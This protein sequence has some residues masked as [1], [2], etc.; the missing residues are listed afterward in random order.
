LLKIFQSDSAT[1]ALSTRQP[2][3]HRT[4]KVLLGQKMV[5]LEVWHPL[6]PSLTS[7]GTTPL[8]TDY[9]YSVSV[10]KLFRVLAKREVS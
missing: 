9:L 5:P 8:K 3:G 1:A 4:E 10:S 6:D 7:S 2:I